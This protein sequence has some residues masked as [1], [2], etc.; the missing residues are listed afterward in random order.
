M[1]KN[2][3]HDDI[4]LLIEHSSIE[5]EKAVENIEKLPSGKQILQVMRII[6]GIEQDSSK[7]IEETNQSLCLTSNDFSKKVLFK[8]HQFDPDN[9]PS[10]ERTMA[11]HENALELTQSDLEAIESGDFSLEFYVDE[12]VES[13]D[14]AQLLKDMSLFE[15]GRPSNYAANLETLEK[16]ELVLLTKDGIALT[17]VGA[18]I[19]KSL[20]SNEPFIASEKFTMALNRATS[21]IADGKLTVDKTLTMLL[22]ES[23]N[24]AITEKQYWTN[25]D[26]LY[27]PQTNQSSLHG[28]LTEY[29]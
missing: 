12:I 7:E 18:L 14:L 6:E 5:Y 23:F 13:Y 10:I 21:L 25:E 27:S 24:L 17:A 3:A 22:K 8:T 28:G 15:I 2:S 19:A 4:S 16:S 20:L 29:K 11:H 9:S 26:E 1:N